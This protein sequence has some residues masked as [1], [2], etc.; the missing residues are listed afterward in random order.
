MHSFYML[1]HQE[2]MNAILRKIKVQMFANV[3]Q[4][5]SNSLLLCNTFHPSLYKKKWK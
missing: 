5:L 4:C 1:Y 2:M 3:T